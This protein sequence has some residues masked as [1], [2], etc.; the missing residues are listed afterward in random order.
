MTA[1][2]AH[3][4]EQRRGS[5]RSPLTA[6][7]HHGGKSPAPMRPRPNSVAL[8]CAAWFDLTP[9]ADMPLA[10]LVERTGS[11]C[12]QTHSASSFDATCHASLSACNPMRRWRTLSGHRPSGVGKQGRRA[13]IHPQFCVFPRSLPRRRWR[14]KAD[15]GRPPMARKVQCAVHRRSSIHAFAIANAVALSRGCSLKW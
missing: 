3:R 10:F 11:A 9:V 2:P 14:T 4:R 12:L 6:R 15:G 13:S 1:Q 5:R 8:R 7:E